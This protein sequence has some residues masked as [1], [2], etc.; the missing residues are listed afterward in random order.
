MRSVAIVVLLLAAP[1]WAQLRIVS[2]NASNVGSATSGPRLGMES[3]LAALGSTESDDPTI[4]GASGIVRPIDVLLLQEARSN[5]TTAASYAAMLNSIHSTSVYSVG[6]VDGGTTGSGTQVIVY[7]SATVR[8]LES[9]AVGVSSTAGQPRQS[10][11]YRL[12]PFGLVSPAADVFLYN[13]HFKAGGT[14]TDEARR[15][16][17]ADAI[18]AD[19]DA[20]PVGSNII[21]AGDLNV[22]NS[23]DDS[24]ARLLV[25]GVGAV[26][27]PISKPGNW[28]D[29][30]SFLAIHTQSPY[31]PSLNPDFGGSTGGMDD[32][33]DQQLVSPAVMNG[34]AGIQYAVNSYY[35]FGNNGTH[36][37]NQPIDSGSGA[38]PTVLTAL[39][40]ILD[41]LP[42]VADFQLRPRQGLAYPGDANLDEKTDI[43]DFSIVAANF[44][45]PAT[46][47]RR[48]DFND[49]GATNIGDFSIL[50]A[51][52]NTV[53]PRHVPE[54]M[55]FL[56]LTACLLW[57]RG[58]D[59]HRPNR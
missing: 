45:V 10:L 23:N 25:A 5:A 32:R 8:L 57:R 15:L 56:M 38:A 33:F 42:I 2:M 27:D 41:H 55:A 53:A 48:G 39:A 34:G 37:I 16:V 6:T 54:P 31:R 49:S 52:F 28:S 18:R 17:E 14:G 20:L 4:P 22:P 40:S 59:H 51:N 13:V 58:G 12:R 19:A 24:Y 1:A 36:A 30:T 3:I 47:W 35:A 21:V 44:N 9:A 43:S 50:A 26:V 29:G 46:G 11:R 7:N